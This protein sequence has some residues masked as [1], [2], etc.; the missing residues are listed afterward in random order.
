MWPSPSGLAT[1]LIAGRSALSTVDP[2]VLGPRRPLDLGQHLLAV[3]PLHLA[4]EVRVV[5]VLVGQRLAQQVLQRLAQVGPH[6][7][8]RREAAVER[9]ER[10]L[11]GRVEHPRL[12][13]AGDA[14]GGVQGQLQRPLQGAAA[15]SPGPAGPRAGP[16][17]RG[18][19]ACWSRLS[20]RS[21]WSRITS[22]PS[23]ACVADREERRQPDQRP[24]RVLA[25]EE[26]VEPGEV[27]GRVVAGVVERPVDDHLPVVAL[28]P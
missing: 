12:R 1:A 19:A 18:A 25:A 6:R 15:G 10:R 24:G 5:G 27:L 7:H 3:G 17:A 20:P 14:V 28:R 16:G 26:A 13:L 11:V 9:P 23:S 8:L 4:L 22:L 2:P 21:R